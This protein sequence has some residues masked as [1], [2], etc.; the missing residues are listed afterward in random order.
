MSYWLAS[1]ESRAPR[2]AKVSAGVEFGCRCGRRVPRDTV[3]FQVVNLPPRL[4]EIF[5]DRWF[6]SEPCVRA[7]F[8]ETLAELDALDTPRAR[9]VTTD[10]RQVYLA[11]VLAYADLLAGS[12]ADLGSLGGP[13]GGLVR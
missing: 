7:F 5:R 3:R 13:W 6:C 1:A 9:E 8:L 12:L 2:I 10:L 11:M 4:N